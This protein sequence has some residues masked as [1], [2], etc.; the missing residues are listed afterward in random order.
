MLICLFKGYSLH[1]NQIYLMTES[2][3]MNNSCF[4]KLNLAMIL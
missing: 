4:L 3:T 2:E 1:S